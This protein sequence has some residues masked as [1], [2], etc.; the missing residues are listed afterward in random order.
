MCVYNVCS[1]IFLIMAI[2]NQRF[3]TF[4]SNK[5]ACYENGK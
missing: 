1:L 2:Y 3:L 5:I 4:E